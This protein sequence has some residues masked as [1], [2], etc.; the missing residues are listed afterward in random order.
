MFYRDSGWVI[1]PGAAPPRIIKVLEYVGGPRTTLCFSSSMIH[2][3]ADDLFQRMKVK[4]FS[5][6]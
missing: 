5:S 6:A 1:V 4:G 2:A 3:H